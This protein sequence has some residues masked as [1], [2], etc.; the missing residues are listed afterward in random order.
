L[1]GDNDRLQTVC[2][3]LFQFL[4]FLG[5]WDNAIWLFEQAEACAIA[6]NDKENAGWQAYR[7]GAVY[8]LRNQPDEVL[9]CAT[10]AAAHWRDSTPRNKA[11]VIDLRGLGHRLKE[12]YPAAIVAYREALDIHRS[13]SS[14][15]EDVSIEMNWLAGAELNNG[16]YDAAERDYREALRI[17]KII[18]D[19]EGTAIYTCNLALLALDREQWAEAESLAREAL[20]LAEK[21]GRQEL[22]AADCH[23]LAQALLKQKPKDKSAL[24]EAEGLSRRAVEIYTRLKSSSLQSAQETLGEIESAMKNAE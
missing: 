14:E 13:I 8:S 16:D 12:D 18:K 22:I 21:V 24:S 15:S 10:R 1:M 4:H 5:K 23:R 3:Q 6:T 17:A 19:D 7:A 2:D 11:I 20:A 9:A